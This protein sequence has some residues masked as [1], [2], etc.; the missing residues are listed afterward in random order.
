MARPLGVNTTSVSQSVEALARA[1]AIGSTIK[2]YAAGIASKDG[3]YPTMELRIDD[4]VV[5]T[6]TQVTGDAWARQFL[7]YAYTHPAKVAANQ[8]KVAFTNDK[9]VTDDDDRV[10]RIDKIILD[11]VTYESEAPNAY[12]VGSWTAEDGC[13]PGY[14][15]REWLDCNGYFLYDQQAIAPTPTSGTASPPTRTPAPTPTT[16]PT[17]TPTPMPSSSAG[18]VEGGP[19]LWCADH[20]EN[21]LSDWTADGAGGPQNSGDASI[22]ASSDVAHRGRYAMKL[23]SNNGGARMFRVKESRT[24]NPYY[25][26]AYL[27]FPQRYQVNGVGNG[28]WN[29][30]Q[31]KSRNTTNNDAFWQLGVNTDADGTMRLSMENWANNHKRYTQTRTTIPVKQWFHLE[32]YYQQSANNTGR[33]T[34]WQDGTLLWDVQNITTMFSDSTESANWSINNYHDSLGQTTIYVDDAAISTSR[35]GP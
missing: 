31:Y 20:E 18:C 17:P 7:E 10:L 28:W 13:A 19:T 27:Y 29:I 26:S 25:Y 15:Q 33:I 8:V 2:V 5:N 35:R 9:Y 6:W 14:K 12:S 32:V 23:S 16:V 24:K 22:T 30:W 34:V 11:G 21:N 4:V 3:V 1:V